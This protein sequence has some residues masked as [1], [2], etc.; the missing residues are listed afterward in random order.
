MIV[1]ALAF[2]SECSQRGNVPS[3]VY[4]AANARPVYD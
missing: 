4:L 2:L 1:G 3:M